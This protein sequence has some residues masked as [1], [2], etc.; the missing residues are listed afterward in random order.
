MASAA[1][2]AC[3]AEE[4]TSP[5]A[6]AS[7]DQCSSPSAGSPTN[8]ALSFDGLGD[9]ATMGTASFVSGNQPQ[10]VSAWVFFASTSGTQDVITLRSD[11]ASGYILGIRGGTLGMFNVNP[12][13][14]RAIVS[15]P[16]LPAVQTWVHLAYVY[17]GTTAYFYV[18]GA[19]VDSS[20]TPQSSLNNQ[21]PTSAWIGTLDGYS[22]FFQGEVDEIRIWG[23]ARKTADILADMQGTTAPDAPGLV[24]YFDCDEICG[25]RLPDE[26]GT[27]NDAT[28]GGGDPAFTPQLVEAD[29]PP[30]S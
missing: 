11:F 6:D 4:E 20:P 21:I 12:L 25:T 29:V 14:G 17:D 5:P 19:V 18:N 3:S 1:L 8:F 28:L 27:G 24:A 7:A 30:D 2:V 15:A 26:S 9:Y 10:A 13:T 23:T 22:Q 16:N